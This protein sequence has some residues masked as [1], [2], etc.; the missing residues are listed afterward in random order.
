MNVRIAVGH[1]HAIRAQTGDGGTI[2]YS[3]ALRYQRAGTR[4]HVAALGPRIQAEDSVALAVEAFHQY[5]SSF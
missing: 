4:D 3:S 2:G 5:L 1:Q